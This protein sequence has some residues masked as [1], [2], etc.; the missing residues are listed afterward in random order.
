MSTEHGPHYH[1]DDEQ[2]SSKEQTWA[3]DD[4]HGGYWAYAGQEAHAGERVYAGQPSYAGHSAHAAQMAHGAIP[5]PPP[6][7]AMWPGG[8][9]PGGHVGPAHA[10]GGPGG[11]RRHVGLTVAAG[12]A[13]I[14][15][16]AGGTAWATSGS[17]TLTTAQI[18]SQTSP[19]LVDVISTLGYQHGTAEGTGMVLTASGEVLTNNHVVAGATSIKVRDIG[20]GRTYT[21]NVLGYSDSNDVAVLKLAGAT[22]LATVKIGD[23]GTAAV[24]QN[25]VALGNAD[26]RDTTPSVATGKITG[27]GASVAAQDQGAGTVEHLNGMIRTNADIQPGDSGG[28]LVNA[29]GE[30]IGMDTAASSANSGGFGTTAAISTTAF[31]IPIDRAISIASQITA[32]KASA[33]VHIGATAFLGVQVASSNGGEFGQAGS[34]VHVAGV[35]PGTAAA[36]A[37]LASGDTILSVG[38]HQLASGSDLQTVMRGLHPADKVSVTWSDAL[39]QTHTATVTLTAGPT[40]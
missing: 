17:G 4:Q 35:V 30:V 8:D 38:G 24:G 31:S 11:R 21:A 23:S 39:G 9:V 28:P 36:S 33:T 3:Q 20:N 37:G 6:P 22:G 12:L 32:G 1:D 14:G 5:P 7:P 40:G 34:G 16:A 15:L 26:G 19:G 2:A 27:L 29:K 25:V 13:V 10:A 18:A